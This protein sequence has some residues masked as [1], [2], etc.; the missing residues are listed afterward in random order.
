LPPPPAVAVGLVWVEF[1]RAHALNSPVERI[2]PTT[3]HGVHMSD[4]PLLS[5]DAQR[6]F[7]EA[8]LERAVAAEAKMGVVERWFEIAGAILRISFAGDR[9]VECLAPALA[10]L[11]IP[12]AS[13]AD[14]V[15]HVWDGESTGIAMAP[16]I[17]AREHFSGRGDI[18]SMASRRFK[19]AFLGAD[20]ALALMD[21]RTRTAVFWIKTAS[22]LPYWAMASPFR[23][24]MHWWM[25]LR[26]CQLVH[27]AA[28]GLDGE[29]VLI[30]GKGGL[31][32][33]TTA[34]ACLDAGLQYLADDFLV[35]EPG[36][37]PRV[38]S[39]YSTGKLEWSQMARFPRFAGLAMNHGSPLG[40][41]AVLYLYPAFGTQLVRSLTLKAILTPAIVDR[42]TSGFEPISR[43]VLERAA[44]FTTLT[45]LPHA[46][47]HTMAF[48]ER[49]CA[50]LPG[51]R[52]ELGSDIAAIPGLIKGLLQRS[53]D[54][55]AALT[56]P[57]AQAPAKESPLVSVIVP[58]RNG[59]SFLPQ[60]VASIRAQNYPAL[61]IIVVDDGSSDDI[62]DVVARL[63][64]TIRYFRQEPSGPAAARNR[65]IREARGELIAFLDVDDLWPPDN[66]NIM[67]D[68]IS[69]RA[70]PDI[71]Q[72]YAQI[73]RQMPGSEDYEFIG[74]PL[75]VFL[76]YLGGA[77]YR[78]R[79][80]DKVGLLDEDLAY[81]EDVDWFFRARDNGLAIERLDQI[82]LYVR[83]H[84]KN[85][86]RDG[87]Q[88]RFALLVLKKIMAQRRLRASKDLHRAGVQHASSANPA[89]LA[90]AAGPD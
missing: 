57:A 56:R 36:P 37:V 51:L 90:D 10:H 87:K 75:E 86:T 80:F 32:K 30:T 52:L 20:V 24:L 11:E 76:D 78:R 82:S 2:S 58:A 1:E 40:D 48:I 34:L 66:L 70:K 65:G 68:A 74:C 62:Q 8:S 12:A 55:I 9:L 33:S 13:R 16:P 71:V 85:M 21:T 46:G 67:V 49:L 60:A 77:L 27:G 81:C 79:A 29:G 59:A 19:S 42:P 41:K 22:D 15:F 44:G 17:C 14:A 63:P 73:M 3:L 64:A 5:E 72:G 53:R 28:I 25:E 31:G 7:F 23:H 47:R 18:W 54:E 50:S 43:P 89:L 38:H 4:V 35:V 69:G 83:R 6:A 61:D 26:G 84:Q 88:R 45:L 39:L